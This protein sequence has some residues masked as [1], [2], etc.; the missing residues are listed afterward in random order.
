M[1]QSMQLGECCF[2][3]IKEAINNQ[4]GMGAESFQ[5]LNRDMVHQKEMLAI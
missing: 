4:Y 3:E 2:K 1:H 5:A